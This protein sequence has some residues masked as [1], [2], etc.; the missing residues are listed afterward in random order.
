M[1]EKSILRLSTFCIIY[2]LPI[3]Y[4]LYLL[5]CLQLLYSETKVVYQW[6]VTLKTNFIEYV[7][8]NENK[9]T[10]AFLK[11]SNEYHPAT[12]PIISLSASS[13][14]R[15]SLNHKEFIATT[16]YLLWALLTSK[17]RIPYL[18]VLNWIFVCL[19]SYI[20]LLPPVLDSK[21]TRLKGLQP[22]KN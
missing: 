21:A 8:L 19:F 16:K 14:L 4:V 10:P 17:L 5:L 12:N 22:P 11:L 6:S 20:T 9:S 13:V 1:T 15:I 3:L 18:H 7:K 2:L